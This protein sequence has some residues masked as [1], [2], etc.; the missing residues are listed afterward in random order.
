MHR[1]DVA[2]H[3]MDREGRPRSDI[4]AFALPDL[5]HSRTTRLVGTCAGVTFSEIDIGGTPP[6]DRTHRSSIRLRCAYDVTFENVQAGLRTDYL[7][8]IANQ[9]G[10]VLGT[11]TCRSCVWVGR[12]TS[13]TR[14][15]ITSTLV[16]KTLIQ[17][18]IRWV[19]R[20]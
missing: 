11:G 15:R 20:G 19:I 1:V 7:F 17:H 4:L 6:I 18:L 9:R 2:T 3:A 8:R 14:C 12:H 5:R 16:P 13:A 10:I